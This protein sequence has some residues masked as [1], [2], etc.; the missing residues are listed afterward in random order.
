MTW[1][2]RWY[3]WVAAM[4][5]TTAGGGLAWWQYWKLTSLVNELASLHTVYNMFPHVVFSEETS[6]YD[7]DNAAFIMLNRDATYLLQ[8]AQSFLQQNRPRARKMMPFWQSSSQQ[9]SQ[10]HVTRSTSTAEKS[11]AL[12]IPRDKFWVSSLFGPRKRASGTMGYHY[13]VDL[14]ASHGTSVF[15]CASGKVVHAGWHG[16]FG[17][18]I[19]IAH[20][21]GM[22]TR[23]AHLSA[24]HV[25]S[26]AY[27]AQGTKVGAVGDTGHVRKNGR[28]ASHLHLEVERYGKRENPLKYLKME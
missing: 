7:E 18:M 28:D 12:P 5:I 6:P 3:M 27:V 13:G 26:G 17:N 1:T 21:D 11:L 15:A 23:Y 2:A 16:G 10:R 19:V 14:A 24:I 22:R 25:T 8:E 4:I 9:R 20:D